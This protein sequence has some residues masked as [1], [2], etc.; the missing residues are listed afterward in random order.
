MENK[1]VLVGLSGG[2]DSSVSAYLLR[3]DGYEVE[4]VYM[5]LHN[6]S[7]QYHEKNIKIVSKVADFLGIKYTILDLSDQFKKEV[8]DYFVQS[9]IDGITPNP[10]I[11]CNKTIK[12]GALFEYMK[13]VG[14]SYLAT[15]HYAK[16]D[17][18]YIYEADDKSKDQSYFLAQINKDVIPHL[19]FPLS[20]Y[21]KEKIKQ[22]A[23]D[24]PQLEKLANQKE[25]QEIC[26]VEGEYTEIL[27]KHTNIDMPGTTLDENGKE[28]GTHKGYM[29]YT[30]GKRRGF[31]VHGAHDPHYVL[32]TNH[33]NNT[34]TVG[35]KDAL[36]V[37]SVDIK[38][39]SMFIYKTNFECGVKLRYR[40]KKLS[41]KV[42]IDKDIAH[43][44]LLEPS[45]GVAP[46][47]FA[48]FY[49]NDKVIGS[50][51]IIKSA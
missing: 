18:K 1:K 21:T 22:I 42:T 14:A 31:Y 38:N 47:Q 26:F 17:G 11:K 6:A 37:N 30:I 40:S 5:K 49:E 45:F 43:I 48:V 50:G 51:I 4:G 15:G 33:I 44:K 2:V 39:L 41:C 34:I 13:S 19:I 23:S 32:S 28:V 46:G 7:K 10:C 3:K 9:Y 29:H 27:E 36:E 20:I 12:F 16:T 24:I 8:Y 25:S 35:K